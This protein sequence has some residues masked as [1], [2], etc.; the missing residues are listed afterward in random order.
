MVNAKSVSFVINEMYCENKHKESQMILVCRHMLLP[1]EG[2][3]SLLKMETEQVSQVIYT[4]TNG[5]FRF[6]V[7]R[8]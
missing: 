1:K 4:S 3:L 2:L 8:T 7:I 6:D 5:E